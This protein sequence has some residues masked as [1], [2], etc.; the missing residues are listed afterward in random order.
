MMKIIKNVMFVAGISALSQA[1]VAGTYQEC[2]S[3]ANEINQ[4]AP[5]QIDKVTVL[6][7]ATCKEEGKKVILSYSYMLDTENPI[8]KQ[9]IES[10]KPNQI[11][12]VCTDPNLKSVLDVVLMEFSYSS[13]DRKFIGANRINKK[14]CRL[15]R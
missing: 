11:N 12:A 4:T 13:R 6:L 5:Q 7:N 3:T 1:A 14:D 9:A 2:I 10:M 8:T 15:A